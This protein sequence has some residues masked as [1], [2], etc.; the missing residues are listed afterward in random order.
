[1]VEQKPTPEETKE[2]GEVVY[3]RIS[4]GVNEEPPK[5]D[6][7]KRRMP[8]TAHLTPTLKTVIA[9]FVLLLALVLLLGY[10]SVRKMDEVG[11]KILEDER[12]H[13]SIRDFV[14]ELRLATTKLDN[15]ARARGRKLGDL[16]DETRPLFDAPLNK[17][18]DGIKALLLRLAAPPYS[19][20]EKWRSLLAHL[21]SFVQATEDPNAYA[22]EGYVK[23]RDADKE[24]DNLLAET[25]N[26]QNEI[27]TASE[28]LEH[29]AARRIYLMTAFALLMGALVAG[30]TIREMQ[31]RFRQ[32][33][34]SMDEARREREFSAQ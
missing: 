18:R 14:L 21:I 16:T 29:A 34:E 28:Q 23:F 22:R 6:Q 3:R 20:D 17:A 12:R 15:E 25:R 33:R 30:Y 1:M 4:P 10:L 2:I 13:T 5:S 31:R 8:L 9:G 26:E 24:L 32:V 11:T 27:L 19:D 7:T